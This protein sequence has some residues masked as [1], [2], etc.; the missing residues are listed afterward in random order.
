MLCPSRVQN[1]AKPF[2]TGDVPPKFSAIRCASASLRQ[3]VVGK[4]RSQLFISIGAVARQATRTKLAI[5][6]INLPNSFKA[7]GPSTNEDSCSSV[8]QYPEAIIIKIA[9]SSDSKIFVFYNKPFPFQFGELLFIRC[10]FRVG[11]KMT[12]P[13][14]LRFRSRAGTIGFIYTTVRLVIANL[15]PLF[16]CTRFLLHTIRTP[17]I[18]E[19]N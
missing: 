4:L 18:A 15:L 10:G 11:L 5:K 14:S 8:S 9:K 17:P 13:G 6:L 19:H 16:N 2:E 3:R 1:F 7:H 12:P